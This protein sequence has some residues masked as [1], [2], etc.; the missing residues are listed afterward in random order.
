MVSATK[1]LCALS[2]LAG[3]MADPRVQYWA[4]HK[5]G[6]KEGETTTE[7]AA[8][9]A[10]SDVCAQMVV[11]NMAAWSSNR[12]DAKIGRLNIV[13]IGQMDGAE[14]YETKKDALDAIAEMQAIKTAH[15]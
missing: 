13:S 14:P 3:A 5:Q 12:Y 4:K 11:A 15:C 7:R 1:T 9:G 2:L 6:M 8:R 10:T